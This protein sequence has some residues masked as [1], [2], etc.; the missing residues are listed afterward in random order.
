MMLFM[1][2]LD[3]Y[4]KKLWNSLKFRDIQKCETMEFKIFA[5]K[6]KENEMYYLKPTA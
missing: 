6:Q 3:L 1:T 5:P 4:F 2:L